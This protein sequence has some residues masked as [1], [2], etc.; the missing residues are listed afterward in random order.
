MVVRLRWLG[1]GE[2]APGLGCQFPAGGRQGVV[3]AFRNEGRFAAK[4][5][6]RGEKV[7]KAA[8]KR[9]FASKEEKRALL[10]T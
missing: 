5:M 6:M 4:K 9:P 2:L 7:N 3:G 10:L 1:G 8:L